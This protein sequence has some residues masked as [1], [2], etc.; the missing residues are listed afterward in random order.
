MTID[1]KGNPIANSSSYTRFCMD[2][3]HSTECGDRRYVE[4]YRKGGEEAARTAN[5]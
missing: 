4:F 1:S 3:T 5:F 2:Y